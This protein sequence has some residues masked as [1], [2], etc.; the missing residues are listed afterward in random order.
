VNN[1]HKNSLFVSSMPVQGLK[2]RLNP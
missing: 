2:F 1:G